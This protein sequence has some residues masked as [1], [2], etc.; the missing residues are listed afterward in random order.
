SR[1]GSQVQYVPGTPSSQAITILD[2]SPTVT[3]QTLQPIVYQNGQTVNAIAINRD[4][5]SETTTIYLQQT[6]AQAQVIY[7]YYLFDPSGNSISNPQNFSVTMPAGVSQVILT[8]QGVQNGQVE[9][10]QLVAWRLLSQSDT[11]AA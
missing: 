7:D 8:M 10:N 1:V 6:T 4:K 2:S 3:L 11:Y 9:P 5:T